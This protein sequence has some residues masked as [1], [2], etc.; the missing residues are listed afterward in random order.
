VHFDFED[1][2]T[3]RVTVS[4]RDL[5]NVTVNATNFDPPG[6][7]IAMDAKNNALL[8]F[9]DVFHGDLA[10]VVVKL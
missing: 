9:N 1:R 7:P 10:P 3:R 6:I 8:F 2:L 5:R 4:A